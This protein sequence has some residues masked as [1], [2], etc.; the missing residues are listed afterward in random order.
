MKRIAC[1]HIVQFSFWDYESFRLSPGG[2]GILGPNG[3]GK[4]TLIDAIQIALM[5]AHGPSLSFNAQSVHKDHRLL[6]DYALGAMRSGDNADKQV[7]TR[8]RDEAVSYITLVFEGDG[9]KDTVS[10]G[11]CLHS[12]VR[13]RDHRVLGMFVLPAVELALEDH[14][15]VVA[16]EGYAPMDWQ[17]FEQLARDKAKSAGAS[18]LIT[19]KA[20]AYLDELLHQIQDPSRPMK[21]RQFV[22]ALKHSINLKEVNS[23]GDFLRGYLVEPSPIDKHGTLSHIKVLRQLSKKIEEVQAQLV[24]LVDFDRKFNNLALAHQQRDVAKAVK[25]LLLVEASDGAVGRLDS[26]IETLKA[27]IEADDLALETLE[28]E[29]DVLR[30][31]HLRLALEFSSDPEGGDPLKA[32]QLRGAHEQTLQQH[33][34]QLESAELDLR[35]AAEGA[36]AVLQESRPSVTAGIAA[37][38]GD[39]E[40]RAKTGLAADTNAVTAL[41]KALSSALLDLQA[42]ERADRAANTKA[43]DHKRGVEEKVLAATRGI[44]LRANSEDDTS[45]AQAVR[46]FRENGIANE[47]VASVVKVKDIT[48]QGAIESFL[49]RNRNSLLVAPGTEREATRLLRHTSPPIYNVTVVQPEHLRSDIGRRAGP[50]TVASVLE[51][52]NAVALAYLRRLLG[53]MRMVSTE[54]ELEKY[55]RALTKDGM[56]SANGGTRRIRLVD[57]TD[58]RLGVKVSE[59]DRGQL[60]DELA[61]ALRDVS[62]AEKRHAQSLGADESVRQVLHRLTPAGYSLLRTEFVNA[63]NTVD[64]QSLPM[65]LPERLKRLEQA[66]KEAERETKLAEKRVG[67]L[68]LRLGGARESLNNKKLELTKERKALLDHQTTHWTSMQAPDYDNDAALVLYQKCSELAVSGP[69]TALAHLDD[70]HRRAEGRITGSQAELMSAFIGYINEHSVGVVDERSDWRKAKVWVSAQQA[71][72][73]QSTLTDYQRQANEAKEAA[74]QSFRSDVKF[75]MREAILKVG[76]E[77]GDLNKI[78]NSCPEFTGGE[79]YAFSYKVAPAFKPLYELITD[80]SKDTFALTGLGEENPV[81]SEAH[82]QL[83]ALLEACEAGTDRGNNPLEDYRLLFNFDLDIK[84]DNKV[85]DT[86]S[87]RIGVASN[88]EH[89]VPYYV[90]AGAALA[91]AYRIK[92]NTPHRGAALMLIDE[93][94]YGMDAQNSYTT[95]T[96]LKGLGLQLIMAGPD[97]DEGK[98]L[99]TLDCF[100]GLYRDGPHS[101]LEYVEV[102]DKARRLLTSDIPEL[103]PGLI[104]EAVTRLRD[105]HVNGHGGRYLPSASA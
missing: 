53:D 97:S 40:S 75:K 93:A 54:A 49:A 74:N 26:T 100:Y 13:E 98:L 57:P 6:R 68:R 71:L 94:F 85:V 23:V 51:S 24:R 55:P 86:L 52:T 105:V 34:R 79:R 12:T 104:N 62:A 35:L 19:T 82:Q 2:T 10:A 43:Q 20:D 22:R 103:N 76:L 90:I 5:G 38:L 91:S 47:T 99:P 45:V 69:A 39:L 9:P 1:A 30:G 11:V 63:R 64:E 27:S 58:W 61:A 37:A 50:E 60:R 46:L 96:F 17:Q 65:E 25:A 16:G 15:E 44:R 42:L 83:V 14:L 56:L 88:G 67:D 78:L 8:K 48:W 32:A 28:Q 84:V 87:K 66:G 89:R 4:T 41:L 72:L 81:T 31:E 36:V 101:H 33:R 21:R 80:E 73:S 7:M 77:I 3:A 70:T 18:P 102:S 92:P 95:A 29:V 59:D